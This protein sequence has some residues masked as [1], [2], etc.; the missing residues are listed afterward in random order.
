MSGSSPDLECVKERKRKGWKEDLENYR[1][2][3]LTLVPGKVMEQIILMVIT[4]H[5]QDCQ[6]IRPSQH[7]F[8]KSRSCLTNLIFFYDQVTRLTDEGKAVDLVYPD[9]SKD[10]DT[11]SH[12]ILL[13]KLAA[14]GLDKGTLYWAIRSR[15][16][17]H[18]LKLC[19]G[20]FMLDIRKKFFTERI[21]RHW[22]GLV[23][24][25]SL[26]YIKK[27]LDVALSAMV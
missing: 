7:G 20:K 18:D 13:E 27:M 21:I 24:S 11:V 5:L 12:N 16:K 1:P 22:N 3:N 17:G 10:F 15:T 6:G 19:Q 14:H 2:I 9:F 26:E 25:L 23:E 8:R 4:Q